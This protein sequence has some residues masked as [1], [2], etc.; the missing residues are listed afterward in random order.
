MG[1]FGYGNF[2]TVPGATYTWDG[3]PNLRCVSCGTVN[4]VA[5][6][7]DGLNQ[8]VS[9]TKGGEKTY[10]VYG[11]HGNLLAEYTPT[12]SNKLIEYIYLGGTSRGKWLATVFN[13]FN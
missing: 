13:W 10:E 1:R 4:E 9:V 3:V 5:N 6:D 7:Y 8:R 2:L 11:S 12:Q